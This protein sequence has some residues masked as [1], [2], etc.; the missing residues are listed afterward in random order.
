V[1]AGAELHLH[2]PQVVTPL[3]QALVAPQILSVDMVAAVQ[4]S[5]RF[6]VVYSF[7]NTAVFYVK[8]HTVGM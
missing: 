4:L 6:E 3:K 8:I 2:V 1:P 7:S 5:V